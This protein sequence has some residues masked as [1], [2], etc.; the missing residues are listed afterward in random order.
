MGMEKETE[1]LRNLHGQ[2]DRQL[3]WVKQ[4]CDMS[5]YSEAQQAFAVFTDQFI[6]YALQEKV[7]MQKTEYPYATHHIG[8][9]D[10]FLFMLDELKE[11]Q[12][13]ENEDCKTIL[14]QTREF[15]NRE[16]LAAS[17]HFLNF[18]ES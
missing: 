4:L 17:E 6:G 1:N 12:S 8:F 15:L 14:G 5:M 13:W 3:G 9:H 7:L 11:V 18:L 2:L 10:E 16:L